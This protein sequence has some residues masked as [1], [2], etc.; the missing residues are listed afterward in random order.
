MRLR[1]SGVANAVL[2]VC[3][4]STLAS[5]LTARTGLYVIVPVAC[6]TILMLL[7]HG[8]GSRWRRR[9]GL[10]IATLILTTVATNFISIFPERTFEQSIRLGIG[11][12]LMITCAIVAEHP[13]RRDAA[14][15][16]LVCVAMLLGLALP[17]LVE[18]PPQNKLSAVPQEV[19]AFFRPQVADPANPNVMAGTLLLLWPLLVALPF[20]NDVGRIGR[21][22]LV[23]AALLLALEV[24]LLQSRG[25]ISG[26]I[27][28][29]A[30]FLILSWRVSRTGALIVTAVCLVGAWFFVN[31][32]D[33]GRMSFGDVSVIGI[34]ERQQVWRCGWYLAQDFLFT[35]FGMGSFNEV[36]N[37]FYPG[38]LTETTVP[39]AHNLL[40]QITGDLGIFATVSWV[41]LWIGA[42]LRSYQAG[43]STDGAV[44][45]LGYALFA[46]QIGMFVHGLTDA[47]TWGMTRPSILVWVLWGLAYA[48]PH[49]ANASMSP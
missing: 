4:L 46:C 5:L 15:T 36:C 42:L 14:V 39:H 22:V 41:V 44:R 30:A 20:R 19:Y 8:S 1:R 16:F 24:V 37:R 11:I 28:S 33:F 31:V 25:A 48:L 35:G 45:T 2:F 32:W 43:Q 26:F 21:V 18:I 29:L 17:L 27:A 6:C 3:G 13:G 49:P 40:L 34:T 47:V 23:G 12:C 9:D 7:A 10:A 38:L